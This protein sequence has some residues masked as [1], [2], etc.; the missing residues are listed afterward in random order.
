MKTIWYVGFARFTLT[1]LSKLSLKSSITLTLYSSTKENS[2]APYSNQQACLS[3]SFPHVLP[4]DKSSNIATTESTYSATFQRESLNLSSNPIAITTPKMTRN[5]PQT[6]QRR[7]TLMFGPN[8]TFAFS[9]CAFGLCAVVSLF[10][11][12]TSNSQGLEA[13]CFSLG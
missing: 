9:L 2:V 12:M 8:V 1:I 4:Q 7:R 5:K 13:V 11:S 10:L 6:A 3:P